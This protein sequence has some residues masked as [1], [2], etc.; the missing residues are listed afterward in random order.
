MV[1][2]TDWAQEMTLEHRRRIIDRHSRIAS[3]HHHP[4][5]RHRSLYRRHQVTKARLPTKPGAGLA[6]ALARYT[7]DVSTKS[8][9]LRLAVPAAAGHSAGVGVAEQFQPGKHR[10]GRCA[11]SAVRD[12]RHGAVDGLQRFGHG[13]AG[14][15]GQRAQHAL[16]DQF[17]ARGAN[18]DGAGQGAAEQRDPGTAFGASNFYLR[19]QS[20]D[21][22]TAVS[23]GVPGTASAR[24][25]RWVAVRAH[26][27]VVRR[28]RPGYPT[29]PAL[30]ILCHAR[31]LR[32]AGQRPHPHPTA[33]EPGHRAAGEQPLV[34]GWGRV[35]AGGGNGLGLY[36]QPG[37]VNRRHDHVQGCH[38]AFDR[39]AEFLR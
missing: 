25:C 18:H 24:L 10:C 4:P 38:A 5:Q 1:A 36:R 13:H 16:Q 28:R 39:T 33:V 15:H 29:G 30:W 32:A 6:H 34:A 37:A 17:S 19:R 7:R 12:H 11:V 21:Q 26:R 3:S 31:H 2:N 9:G 8:V 23:A 35:R 20:S 27:R 22:R 14:N